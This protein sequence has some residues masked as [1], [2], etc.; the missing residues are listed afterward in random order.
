MLLAEY[1][2]ETDIAVQRAEERE[3]A[4]AEGIERGIEQGIAQGSYQTKL[5][6]AAAFK[7]LGVDITKLAEGTGLSWEEI[8]KL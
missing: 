8:E 2:Y 7:K 5:E 3:I 6:T 4:F 1:D